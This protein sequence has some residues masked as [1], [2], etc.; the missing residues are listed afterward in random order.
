M[1]TLNKTKLTLWGSSHLLPHHHFQDSFQRL[2]LE[3]GITE[4]FTHPQYCA[5]S[6]GVID[7]DFVDK[8]KNAV[9]NETEYSQVH[10]VVI[11]GNNLRRAS[12]RHF[13]SN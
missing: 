2:A 4:R 1:A 9:L 13:H 3:S 6:G 8:F 11:G 12:R 5:K 7:N 10:I